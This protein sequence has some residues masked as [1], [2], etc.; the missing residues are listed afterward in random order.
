VVVAC[1]QV[2][3]TS[4]WANEPGWAGPGWYIWNKA[5]WAPVLRAKQG[6]AAG[7]YSTKDQCAAARPANIFSDQAIPTYVCVYF[8][9]EA[10]FARKLDEMS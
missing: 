7:P 4:S 6:A 5:V 3:P 10:E 1:S 2:I 8:D 9:G